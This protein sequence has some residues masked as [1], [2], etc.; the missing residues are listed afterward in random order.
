MTGEQLG[1]TTLVGQK[2]TTS[3]SG[4]NLDY[5]GYPIKLAEHMALCDGTAFSAR[6]AVDSIPHIK[7]AKQAIKKAFQ[8]QLDGLGFG[9]VEIL[10]SCPTNW[11]MTPEDAHERI[12]NEMIPVFPL[13]IFK[14]IT[15][16]SDN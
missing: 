13:G 1:P 15:E 10:S 2:T 11:R 6:V 8:V 5:Y 14:D 16:A 4:R 7:Q 3:P 12:R 9:F